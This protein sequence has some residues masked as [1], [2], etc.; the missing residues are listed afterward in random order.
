MARMRLTFMFVQLSYLYV[1]MLIVASMARGMLEI[2]GERT[3][4]PSM[5]SRMTG[6]HPSRVGLGDGC[7]A[8]HPARSVLS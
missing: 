6:E 3:C 2:Q 8:A 7:A 4:S 1:Y 5:P